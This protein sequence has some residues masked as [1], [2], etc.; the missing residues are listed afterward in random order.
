MAT[1]ELNLNSSKTRNFNNIDIL[2]PYLDS[3]GRVVMKIPTL[4]HVYA[5]LVL[6][7]DGTVMWSSE[8]SKYEIIRHLTSE[9]SVTIYGS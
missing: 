2:R 7:E 5:C 6:D 3:E 1:C 9:E 8:P 4:T